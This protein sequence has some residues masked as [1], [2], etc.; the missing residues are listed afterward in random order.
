[1][2]I[3]MNEWKIK[4]YPSRWLFN[5]WIEKCM[6]LTCTNNLVKKLPTISANNTGAVRFSVHS[7]LCSSPSS[8]SHG[9]FSH[10]YVLNLLY[11]NLY[12]LYVY[13]VNIM[14]S[15]E[16]TLVYMYG[17]GLYCICLVHN[18]HAF[19]NGAYI[20]MRILLLTETYWI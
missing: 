16:R 19:F 14:N 5:I 11:W 18:A 9:I 7:A 15:S 3:K 4:V 1:M 12:Q 6:R 2:I 8:S 10:G 13:F 20:G 17:M